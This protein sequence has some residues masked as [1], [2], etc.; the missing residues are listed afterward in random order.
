MRAHLLHQSL[1][2][3]PDHNTIQL[4]LLKAKNRDTWMD[5]P[6]IVWITDHLTLSCL[7]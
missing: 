7:N 1:D 5:S 6:L 3:S 4:Q 2:S